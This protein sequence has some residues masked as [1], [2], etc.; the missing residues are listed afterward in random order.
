MSAALK[1][2][3]TPIAQVEDSSKSSNCLSAHIPLEEDEEGGDSRKS[4]VA[5]RGLTSQEAAKLLERWGRNELEE[6]TKPK[7]CCEI[8]PLVP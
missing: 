8:S 4:F 2:K 1:P 3:Y 7:V 5:S 6:K